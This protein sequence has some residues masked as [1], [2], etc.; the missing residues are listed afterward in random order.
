M[1]RI[2][3][4]GKPSALLVPTADFDANVS[5]LAATL[6]ERVCLRPD[7]PDLARSSLLKSPSKLYEL[8][9]QSFVFP[10]QHPCSLR[11]HATENWI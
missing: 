9:Q 1:F 7:R 4:S 2:E 11:W 5:I 6:A 8:H 10:T 3:D